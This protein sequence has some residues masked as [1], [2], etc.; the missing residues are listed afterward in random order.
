L[1]LG[2]LRERLR[3][4]GQHALATQ[5]GTAVGDH[6][7]KGSG[8]TRPVPLRHH[9]VKI[10]P[11]PAA[12]LSS[13]QATPSVRV[14]RR[15]ALF[16]ILWAIASAACGRPDSAGSK[17][18]SADTAAFAWQLPPGLPLPEVPAD[19]PMSAAKVELGRR[20][21]FDPRLSGDGVFSCASCHRQ[22]YAFADGR[23]LPLGS[24]GQLHPRNS[25]ALSNVV[26]QVVFGWADPATRSLEAQAMIPLF[27]EAPVEMGL[28]A[29]EDEVLR[30]LDS[31]PL[32][33]ALFAAAFAS[34]SPHISIRNVTRGIA[35]FE[36]TFI[37]GNAP[38]DLYK[39]GVAGAIS[40]AAKRGEAL[41]LGDRLNCSRCHSG[42]L[43][44][45]AARWRGAPAS[46]PEFLNNG[47][48]N[49]DGRGAYPAPNTGLFA[50]TGVASDM[51]RFKVPSLRNVAVTYPYMHDGSVATLDDAIDHYASGGRKLTMGPY[52]GD[53][54]RNPYKSALV[55]GFAITSRE[56]S[57]VIAFLRS[58]TDS[59]FLTDPKLANPW[60]VR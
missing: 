30:R 19:N 58:L 4:V 56:K 38:Y 31:V 12:F 43:F 23:N 5:A 24:G 11:L 41:F 44:T 18:P 16:A 46:D 22:E 15:A 36:R 1:R 7:G 52:P 45:N 53:G 26:Y 13:G 20:L 27:G 55:G 3:R 8:W 49:I 17:L 51:G 37:S 34:D 40:E 9:P 59:T 33:R 39:R 2:A 32:Y 54:S 42:P 50:S 60:I 28:H 57:D 29:K 21:F 48:Y 47:L 14:R 6:A 35:A 25:M 10:R